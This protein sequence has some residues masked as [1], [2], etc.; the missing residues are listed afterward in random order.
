MGVL[1]VA[2][3]ITLAVLVVGRFNERPA[4]GPVRLAEP[5]GSRIAAIA[6]ADGRL[7]VHVAG[8]GLPDRVRVFGLRGLAEAGVELVAP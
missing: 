3:T 7:V 4:A 2:G 5:A 8:G 6:A 1:I